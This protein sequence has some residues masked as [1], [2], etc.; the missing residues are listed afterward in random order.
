MIKRFNQIG[1]PL[2]VYLFIKFP[3]NNSITYTQKEVEISSEKI[4]FLFSY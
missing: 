3:S 2:A 1:I 4:S